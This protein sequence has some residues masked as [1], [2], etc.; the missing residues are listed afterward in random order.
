MIRLQLSRERAG[1]KKV[2][3]KKEELQKSYQGRKR[4]TYIHQ[5]FSREN[6]QLGM[7]CKCLS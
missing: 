5:A 3:I 1:N 2:R 4:L 6:I 7:N